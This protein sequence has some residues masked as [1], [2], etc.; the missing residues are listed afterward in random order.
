MP[1]DEALRCS[2]LS[3]DSTLRSNVSVGL[4]LDVLVYHIDSLEMPKGKRVTQDD[5]YFQKS[6][7]NGRKYC[8]QVCMKFQNLQRIIWNN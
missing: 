2:L 8:V 4:P 5:E 3:F 1:L 7:N 6:V